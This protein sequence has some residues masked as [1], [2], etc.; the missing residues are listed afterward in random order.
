MKI[1]LL[2]ENCKPLRAHPTDSGLDLRARIGPGAK[3]VIWPACTVVVPVGI[4]IELPPGLEGQIRP[5]SGL[6]KRGI[7]AAFGT[8]DNGYRGEIK[9]ALT[10][11]TGNRVYIK[12]Y[13]RIAQMVIAPVVVLGIEYV[14]KLSETERGEKGHGSTGI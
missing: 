12:P 4:A 14:D 3:I 2:D 7:I 13:D 1:K 11:T 5:R 9:V 10:N 6:S 8:I